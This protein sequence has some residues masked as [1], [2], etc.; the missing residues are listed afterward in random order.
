MAL[1][2]DD[3]DIEKNWLHMILG[4][5]GDYYIRIVSEDEN[6]IKTAKGVRVSTSGGYAPSDV[7]VA[8][9][10]LFRALEKHKLNEY[11]D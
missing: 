1:K 2:S 10:E 7:K 9:A 4:G 6:G 8:A 3:S 11:P 5:N